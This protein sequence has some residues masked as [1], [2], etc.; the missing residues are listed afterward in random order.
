MKNNRR[1]E[2]LVFTGL[3][4]AAAIVGAVFWFTN[5]EPGNLVKIVLVAILSVLLL[6]VYVRKMRKQAKEIKNGEVIEDELSLKIKLYAS[7]YSFRYGIFLWMFI[8]IFHSA[9]DKEET[10]LGGGILGSALIYGI[11]VWYFKSTLNFHGEQN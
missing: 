7:Y 4:I 9:F 3:V 8:F 1:L 11:C 6:V 2:Y 10:M 5:F